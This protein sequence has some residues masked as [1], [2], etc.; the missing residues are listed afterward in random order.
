MKA[1]M[2]E[3]DWGY[4]QMPSECLWKPKREVKVLAETK[5]AIKIKKHWWSR[6]KWYGKKCIGIRFDS[7]QGGVNVS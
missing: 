5:K 2:W 3:I 7:I 4:G 1:V 6:P